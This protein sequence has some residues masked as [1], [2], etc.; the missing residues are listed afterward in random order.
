MLF[1][2]ARDGGVP[3]SSALRQVSPTF[4]SPVAAVWTVALLAVLFTLYTPAYPTIAATCVLFL[5]VSYVLPTLLGLI[6]HGRSW[7]VMG[8]WHLGAWYRP[9][10]V[11]AGLGCCLLFVIGVQPPN[12]QALWVLSGFVLFLLLFWFAVERRRFRGPPVIDRPSGGTS[13]AD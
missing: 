11:L 12:E 1:A 2:F 3:F 8:P 6:A 7:T 13:P 5:Y 10:A 4:R 9:L